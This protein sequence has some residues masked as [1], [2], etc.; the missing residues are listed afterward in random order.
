MPRDP[1]EPQDHAERT[2]LFR[3]EVIGALTR[4]DLDRGELRAEIAALA[5]RAFRPPGYAHTRTFSVPTLERW[6]YA[7][8][9]GG[10]AALHPRPRSDRG[11]ARELTAPQRKLLCD[12]RRE[13]PSASVPLILRTLV[14]DGR[15]A[16]GAVSAATVAR[17]FREQGLDRVAYRPGDAGKT[18]LRWQAERPGALWHGDVCHGPAL[19]VGGKSRPLRIHAFLDDASRYVVAL[20]AHHAE[21]EVD[22]LGMLVAA[23]RRHG[24][25]DALYLDNGSTYVGQALRLGCERLGV[26]LLHARPYDPQ[27][28]GKMERFWRTLREGCLD[29]LGSLGSLHDVQVRL[30]AFLDQ[31]YHHAAHAGLM[32]KTPAQVWDASEH[33]R[34]ADT[35][36][37]DDLRRALTVRARR[38]VRRDTTVSVDGRAW[39]LDQ[40]FLAGRVVTVAYTLVGDDPPWVEHDGKRFELHALDVHA[41]AKTKRPR[42]APAPTPTVPFDPAG[43]LLDRAA[44]RPPRHEE[45]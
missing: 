45:K 34:R 12:I 32:G 22:M 25:P 10:L 42:P 21:R 14:A 23:L 7:Y 44:G 30:G 35:V 43:A 6:Y 36:G 5:Q 17:L 41:N 28:R 11:R 16:A 24:A 38:R 39:Q 27:A 19:L 33:D 31:H 9:R 29:H 2:A 20:E 26:T 18:R 8:R 40:G 37:E 3:S 13:H 15:L 1:L 4:R